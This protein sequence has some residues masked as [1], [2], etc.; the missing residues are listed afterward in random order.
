M[1]S[2]YLIVGSGLAS[3]SFG[4]LMAKAGKK[5]I[6]LEAH[7][8]PGG[9]GHTFEE[10]GRYKFN[11]Q[12]HYVWN[13]GKGRNVYNFLKKLNVHEEVTFEQ[14]DPNGFDHMRMPGYALDIPGDLALL[15]ERLQAL[16]P[17][18][19]SNIKKFLDTVEKTADQID[20]LPSTI[21]PWSLLLNLGNNLNVLKYRNATLQDVFD[22]FQLPLEAQTLLALQWPDFMLPPRDLSFFAWSVL[23]IGYCR[24]AYYPTKHFEQVI[25]TL[26]NIIQNHGGEIIY[27]RKVTEFIRNGS[28][29]DGVHAEDL[30][31]SGQFADYFGA[32]VICNIDPKRAAEMIG[33]EHFSGSV[34]KKLL[35]DYSPSNFMAYC[36]V[37]DLEL[38]DFGFGRWNLF[39]TEQ[40][41]LNKAFDAMHRHGDY[42]QPSFVITTPTLLTDDHSD[43]PEDCQVVELL[44][45]ANYQRFHDLKISDAGRYRDKKHEVFDAMLDVIE[46]HYVPNFRQYLVFKMI[47][48]PTTNERYCGSPGGNSYGSNLTPQN[49]AL[50]RLDHRTS[51]D[52]FYFCNA[53]SGYPGFTGSITTGCRLYEHLTGDEFLKAIN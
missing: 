38:R 35:Y 14:Y 48:S 4:A 24:G 50:N 29:I 26:V 36:V 1:K 6:I 32:T 43:C 15:Y 45:V 30:L 16:F 9:Y 41:D 10:G 8:I 17:A 3:L 44:T 39:H 37:K 31:N 46:K 12:L 42:S 27:N 40:P 11:A 49:I 20:N 34:K 53:S 33:F 21:K 51:L 52:N 7:E 19:A 5:V 13:C 18:H 25:N 2:D 23:F 22:A 28:R 47:G